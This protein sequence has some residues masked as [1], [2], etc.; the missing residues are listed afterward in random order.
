[1]KTYKASKNLL[2]VLFCL[3]FLTAVGVYIGLAKMDETPHL[4]WFYV[5]WMGILAW[6]WYS[7]LKVP[8]R[9]TIHDDTSIEFFSIVR[10]T[11][12]S[13]G[14]IE[15]LKNWGALIRIKYKGGKLMIFY[16]MDGLH[17]FITTVKSVNPSI[18]LKGI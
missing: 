8:F 10:R 1:M 14:Q 4:L 18:E 13:P 15:S 16:Q 5:S 9:I 3:V 11:I 6:V 17:D 2:F 12:I 7:Y